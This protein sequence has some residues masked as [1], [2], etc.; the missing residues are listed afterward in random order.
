MWP[1]VTDRVTR[2]IGRSISH[3]SEPCKHGWTDWD[4]V[5]FEDLEGKEPCIR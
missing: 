3:T 1:V 2:S 4:V 5:W